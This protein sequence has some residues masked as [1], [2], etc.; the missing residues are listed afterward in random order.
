MQNRSL[1]LVV[2]VAVLAGATIWLAGQL[3]L[4]GESLLFVAIG[5]LVLIAAA[6]LRLSRRRRP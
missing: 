5:P 6:V 1:I 4:N 3:A 2:L